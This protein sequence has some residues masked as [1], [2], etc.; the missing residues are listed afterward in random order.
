MDLELDYTKEELEAYTAQRLRGVAKKTKWWIERASKTFW[1]H[2]KGVISYNTINGFREFTLNNW[3]SRDAWSKVLSFA[4]S[5]L[6]H[7]AKLRMDTRYLNFSIFLDMPKS[8]KEKKRTTD[9]VVT[10]KDVQNVVKFFVK[11]WKKGEISREKALSHVAQTLFGA[12]TGQRPYT[13]ARLRVDQ[14]EEGLKLKTPT[15][16]VEAKQDKVRMEHYVPP[17]P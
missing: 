16:L 4:K 14:F 13:L 8:I 5:F 1:E 10:E 6:E 17:S 9:R 12:Y 7:L 11:K 15:I 3:S 2:T